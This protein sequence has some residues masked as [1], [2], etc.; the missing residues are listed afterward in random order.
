VLDHV[1]SPR[2]LLIEDDRELQ[3]MLLRVLTQAG[4]EVEIA[5]D[6]Q[7]GLHR[8]LTR[9]YNVLIVDRGLPVIEGLDLTRRLRRHGVRSP[10]LILTAYGTVRDRVAG[11]DAGAE[12]Y[13]VK[14]FEIDELLARIRALLRR[15]DEA[16]DV[17][18]L[19]AGCL[20]LATRVARR[21]DGSE[22]ELSSREWSLL[23]MLAA[24]PNRVFDRDELRVRVF[25][26][27]ESASIVDTYVHY[28]RRKLG[29]EVIRTVR[30]L[31]YRAGRL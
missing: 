11:L 6:G 13:V 16:G 25:G 21:S 31:G 12:D 4:Y 29:T 19:G 30:G 2:L 14:P 26:L 7:C 5:L 20:D 22:V 18:H 8:A 23:A 1:V 17:I 3:Q 15:G 28:V 27:A 10:V 9:V 24:R